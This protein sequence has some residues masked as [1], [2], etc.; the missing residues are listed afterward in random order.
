MG[1]DDARQRIILHDL[2]DL[3]RLARHVTRH[4]RLP[5]VEVSLAGLSPAELQRSQSRFNAIIEAGDSLTLTLLLAAVALQVGCFM[6]VWASSR[7]WSHLGWL[8]VSVFVAAAAGKIVSVVWV[9]ARLLLMVH[10]LRQR[11]ARRS[12]PPEGTGSTTP[13]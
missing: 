2:A 9:R 10:R 11:L 7:S 1:V 12:S 8:V 6:I 3:H 13:D 4:W 5:K